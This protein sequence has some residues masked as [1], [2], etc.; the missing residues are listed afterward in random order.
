MSHEKRKSWRVTF[1]FEKIS[2]AL[3]QLNN[4]LN[5]GDD[6]HIKG[7]NT[8]FMQSIEAINPSNECKY[9]TYEKQKNKPKEMSILLKL[10]QKAFPNDKVYKILN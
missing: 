6:I 8:N 3:I 9:A 2:S 1:Y 10:N 7:R 4:E 5:V